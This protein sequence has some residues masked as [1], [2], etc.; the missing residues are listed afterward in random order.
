MSILSLRQ[1]DFTRQVQG[2][3][4]VWIDPRK[5]L[6]HG[7]TK[8]PVAKLR[9]RQASRFLPKAVVSLAHP[10]LKE[11]EPFFIPGDLF[12]RTTTLEANSKYNK[13]ADF[14]AHRDTVDDS[15]WFRQ[16]M[17][18][19]RTRGVAVHKDIRMRSEAEVRDFFRDYVGGLA[20]SLVAEGFSDEKSS[21]ESTAVI[22]RDGALVKTGSGNHRFNMCRVLGVT[23]FPL[24]IV[25]AHR[26]WFTERA[27]LSTATLETLL[28]MIRKVGAAHR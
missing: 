1:K 4:V 2:R 23:P 24:K 10:A 20:D 13:V 11:R 5:V 28:D 27:D 3:A 25:G 26:D 22:N 14:I 9:I 19:L 17:D 21:Y 12:G 7:G 18:E 6:Y 8:W 15:I 16:L